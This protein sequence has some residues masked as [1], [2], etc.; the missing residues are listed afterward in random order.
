MIS[1]AGTAAPAPEL[2]GVDFFEHQIRPILVEHCYQCH[3]KE[4]EK[5][6]GGLLLDTRDGLLKGG[7]TGP[8]IV[9]GDPE[10]SLLIKAVRY[11]DENLQMPPKGKKLAPEQIAALETWVKMGAP[12]PRTSNAVASVQIVN[13]EKTR[14]HWAYRPIAS[15]PT[16][17]VK[18]QRWVQTPVD[19]FVLHKL[20]AKS[21]TPS[22][23]AD[24]RTLIRRATYDLIGLPPTLAEVD[25]FL[26]DRSPDA[27][28]K[29]V[30]RL[31]TSPQYG[32]R[33]ARYW[34]DVARYADTKGYVF[35]EE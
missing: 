21:L 2:S 14:Q 1:A 18:N 15:P 17:S 24:R 9:P 12:D 10:K 16:P 32:E 26:A 31:L 13:R 3:S 20:E 29:V 8:G 25:A 34:L 28:A 11:E 19:A 30:D 22:P 6:K 35:E 4:S 7:D 33:W 27:F 23:R 5:I